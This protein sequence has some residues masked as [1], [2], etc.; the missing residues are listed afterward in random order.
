MKKPAGITATRKILRFT[1]HG[2][3]HANMRSNRSSPVRA[4]ISRKRERFT[5][6]AFFC[7]EDRSGAA[8]EQMQGP[9][10]NS[11]YHR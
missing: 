9:C 10:R 7:K 5:R 11:R 8:F 4:Y 2:C 6:V 3:W 1:S